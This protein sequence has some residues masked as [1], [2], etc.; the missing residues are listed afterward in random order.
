M[1]DFCLTSGG[2]LFGIGLERGWLPGV[3]SP[4]WINLL[5]GGVLLTIGIMLPRSRTEP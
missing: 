1:K 4:F 2:I 5:I 3:G